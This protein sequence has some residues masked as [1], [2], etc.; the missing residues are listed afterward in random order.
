MHN[1][2]RQKNILAD[3][4]QIIQDI[5]N[6]T[7]DYPTE[8]RSHKGICGVYGNF[9]ELHIL[10]RTKEDAETLREESKR[11]QDTPDLIVKIYPPEEIISYI[12]NTINQPALEEL[13]HD[14]LNSV[15]NL[16]LK[17]SQKIDEIAKH[18]LVFTHD[19]FKDKNSYVLLFQI[20]MEPT[21]E[22][23]EIYAPECIR[24]LSSR[25][26][27]AFNAIVSHKHYNQNNQTLP[28]LEILAYHPDETDNY[29]QD[30]NRLANSPD[31]P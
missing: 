26:R 21:E 29:Q 9:P 16:P 24:T 10:A 18:N 6:F 22:P 3:T 12:Q 1:I 5:I 28:T 31:N 13:Y 20:P 19:L 8:I 15:H 7:D 23:I 25:F 30:L 17:I 4:Y 14:F 2:T 27:D 11:F